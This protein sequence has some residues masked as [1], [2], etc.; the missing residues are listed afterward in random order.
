MILIESTRI[1]KLLRVAG[2]VLWPFIFVN[3]KH[4]RRLVN[5]ERIHE[6]QIK[7]CGVLRFYILYLRYH[8][9]FGYRK[10]PFEVEAF[11]NDD[12]LNYLETRKN[13]SWYWNSN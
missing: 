8:F 6:Y 10:N 3:N 11:E 7:E 12:N 1:T 2:I 5:H 13:K 4:N 9:K